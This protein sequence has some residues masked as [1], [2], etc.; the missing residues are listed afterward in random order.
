MID[1]HTHILPHFDDGARDVAT[2]VAMLQKEIAQGVDCVVFT[3]HYYG[4]KESP[5][6]FIERRKRA[7]E[8]LRAHIPEGIEI[9]MGAEVHFTGLSMPDYDE[10]ALLRIEGT[11][12]ILLELP[13][14]TAWTQSLMD[15]IAEFTRDS[16]CTPIIAH[17]ERYQE[18]LKNPALVTQLIKMGCLIQVNA[19]SFV[20]KKEKNFAFTLLKHGF[21]HCI[22]SDAH[23]TELRSPNCIVAKESMAGAGFEF[24]WDRSQ[25]IMKKILEG[26]RLRVEC[27]TTIKK[28]FGK[29]L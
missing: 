17:V 22:G 14:T 18:V 7:F 15:K 13:F 11:K 10:L 4:R 29:Y 12:Y 25:D 23:D 26:N 2:A 24:L 8:H 9:R 28:F 3:P 21:V 16:G 27:S 6:A 1:M 5:T 20:T 19:D